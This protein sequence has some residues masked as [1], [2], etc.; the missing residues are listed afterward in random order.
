VVKLPLRILSP[1]LLIAVLSGC[2]KPSPGV[3]VASVGGSVRMEALCWSESDS[4][5]VGSD[6]VLDSARTPTL[7]II[8]GEF[9]GVSVDGEIAESGWA[10]V[11]NG[12]R[13]TP[14]LLKSRYY[15]FTTG[16]T[17]FAQGPVE[18]QIYALTTDN[19]VRGLW[20]LQVEGR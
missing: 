16:E 8:P 12:K 11:V 14:E 15:R 7:K 9:I 5:P 18:M 19:K 6:C 2:E 10:I 17:S 4:T 3:S 20:A 13:F 1:L